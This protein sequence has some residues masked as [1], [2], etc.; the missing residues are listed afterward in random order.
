MQTQGFLRGALGATIA[1]ALMFGGLSL[2]GSASHGAVDPGLGYDPNSDMGSLSAITRLVGAQALWSQGY[3][4]K[5][6]GVALIDT[7]VTRVPGLASAGQVIDGPDLS[8]D[9]PNHALAHLDGFGHGTHMASIIVGHDALRSSLSGCSTC[10]GSV[11]SDTTKFVGIA[12]E[13][14]LVNLKV[15][16]SDG[17][18]DVSQVVAAI[19]WAVAHRDDPK[20]KIKVI[21]I[22]YGT[23]SLQDYHADPIAFATENAWRHGIV[24]VAA[25]GNDGESVANLADPAYDPSVVAVGAEDPNGTMKTSD[26]FVPTW[27]QHGTPDRPVDM[28]A[29]G[30]HVLGLRVPGSLVDVQNP[31]AVVGGRFFRG[32]GTSQATA[33]VTGVVALL[34]QRFPTATPDQIKAMIR[35]TA[36]GFGTSGDGKDNYRGTGVVDGSQGNLSNYLKTLAQVLPALGLGSLDAARG[37][38]HLSDNGVLLTGE[39]DIFADQWKPISWI[40]ANTLGN[41]WVGGNWRGVP[42]AGATWG[43]DGSWSPTTWPAAD[44]AGQPWTAGA[45]PVWDGS[46]WRGNAWRADRWSGNAWRSSSWSGSSWR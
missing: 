24:V 5:G 14:T 16:A 19:D 11:L 37:G 1:G 27:A 29:P 42:W 46:A 25:A 6:V 39:R 12:P 45:T 36:H 35:G 2:G 32:S 22:S 30:V 17:A 34:R 43:S 44:W 31:S 8:F 7:G 3:T 4:G 28:V 26:D 15:G 41:A 23:N 13:A 10:S 38:V 9:S 40:L 20:L 21:N 33:V 18:T